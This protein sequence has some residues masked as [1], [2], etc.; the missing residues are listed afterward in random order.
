M[1]LPISN[2]GVNRSFP[3]SFCRTFATK[4]HRDMAVIFTPP[5]RLGQERW[6]GFVK[7]S[8]GDDAAGH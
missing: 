7:Y 6:D 4:N 1:V 3:A 2:L 5:N 8:H